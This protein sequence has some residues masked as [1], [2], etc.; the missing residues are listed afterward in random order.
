MS[1]R[2][3][4]IV[5]GVGAHSD[6]W[7]GLE[8]TSAAI[9]AVLSDEHDCT[10]VTTDDR[11]DLT[12]TDLVVVNVSGEFET[13]PGDS[14]PVVDELVRYSRCGGAILACHSSALGFTDDP[15]WEALMG[16]VWVTGVTM[17]PQI[18]W[19]LVQMS[20]DS[21][22]APAVSDFELYDERYSHLRVSD[23]NHILAS[24]TEDG[25]THPLAWLRPASHVAGPVIYTALGHGVEA[26]ESVGHQ[27]F[28]RSAVDWLAHNAQREGKR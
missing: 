2:K 27:R 7:H 22:L 23:D 1:R 28:L 4:T 13:K 10:I 16:G 20:D 24:H 17:H 11:L 18:G 26:Y 12:D 21:P 14:E 6:P 5:Q 25:M 19:S 3:A 8:S 15:R 9:V